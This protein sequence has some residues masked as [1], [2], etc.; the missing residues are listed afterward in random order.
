DSLDKVN[1]N[2]NDSLIR[3]IEE[4]FDDIYLEEVK[5]LS[6]S[7]KEILVNRDMSIVFSPIHGASGKM[8]PAAL[9]IFGFE[10]IHVVKEQ[11]EP[12][13]N[14]PTVIFPNPEEAEA[15][16]LSL[17]LAREVGAELVLA[18]DPDGDRYASAV[19]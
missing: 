18:C 7:P 8:V 6:M 5:K 17:R 9:R 14:F 19:P 16:E 11:A 10:N 13:G 1:S 4:D 3:Y 12:D 15:L 2:K